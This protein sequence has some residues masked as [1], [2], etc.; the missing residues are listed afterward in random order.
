MRNN[1]PDPALALASRIYAYKEKSEAWTTAVDRYAREVL[2]RH[3]RTVHRW[4]AGESPVPKV[5]A[6]SLTGRDRCEEHASGLIRI[7][8]FARRGRDEIL[9]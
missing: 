7:A 4:L 8:R 2:M 3:P 6:D 5:V 9:P 1:Q